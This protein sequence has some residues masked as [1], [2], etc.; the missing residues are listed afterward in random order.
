SGQGDVRSNARAFFGDRFFRNLHQNLLALA[1]EIGNCRLAAFAPRGA[2]TS[3]TGRSTTTIPRCST[4]SL[5]RFRGGFSFFRHGKLFVVRLGQLS[6]DRVIRRFDVFRVAV[7]LV[8]SVR[9][10]GWPFRRTPA[11]PAATSGS[12]LFVHTTSG[13]ACFRIWKG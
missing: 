5:G 7:C 9:F 3:T 12:E 10:A 4:L 1:Q 8:V 2:T 13:N 6:L 11:P